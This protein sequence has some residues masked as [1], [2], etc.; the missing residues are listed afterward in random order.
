METINW[1][2][3]SK[4]S[5]DIKNVMKFLEDLPTKFEM[6]VD[7][8]NSS[9][10]SHLNN[11][12][13]PDINSTLFDKALSEAINE[14]RFYFLKLNR[15]LKLDKIQG[16]NSRNEKFAKDLRKYG[17]T[18]SSLQLKA[19]T[20]NFLWNNVMEKSLKFPQKIIEF[21]NK[22]IAKLLRKFLSYLNSILG[23]FS[24]VFPGLE[25]LKEIK[26]IIEVFAD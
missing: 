21:A 17:L 14:Y 24:I 22:D 9:F 18:G 8:Q 19:N 5:T 3:Y 26:D 4:E 13:D 1:F 11:F 25:A 7:P 10:K 23:S 6:F 16:V 2:E 12:E 15:S 20:L